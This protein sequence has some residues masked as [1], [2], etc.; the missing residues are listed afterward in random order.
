[1]PTMLHGKSLDTP[2]F[3]MRSQF[4]PTYA[5]MS[6]SSWYSMTGFLAE[7]FGDVEYMDSKPKAYN[8][9]TINYNDT[10]NAM[11][12]GYLAT[13]DMEIFA[14]PHPAVIILPD[15]DGVNTYE[16]ER[17]TLL[18]ELGY[19]AFAADIYG[20]DLQEGL[21]MATKIELSTLYRNDTELYIQRISA[22]V[23]LIQADPMVDTNSI[24]IIGYCFGGTGIIDYAFSG[25]GVKA[26]VSFHG[27]LTDLDIPQPGITIQ[28]YVLVLSGGIDDAQGNQTELE[29]KLNEANA[30]WEITRYAGVDHAFTVWNGSL[31]NLMA[32]A[33][34]FDSMISLFA[35]VMPPQRVSATIAPISPSVTYAPSDIMPSGMNTPVTASPVKTSS[36]SMQYLTYSAVFATAMMTLLML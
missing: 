10:G 16:K 5:T 1:M 8:V 3:S 22:A 15:W 28:P 36:A 6:W 13:P 14:G 33:R 9:Q 34:S 21:D 12:R 11:L 26:A 31:Y 32:D 25:M 30:T 17:A 19:M 27:G 24:G 23:L 4:F 20:K 2:E 29:E 18:S 35:K 7:A